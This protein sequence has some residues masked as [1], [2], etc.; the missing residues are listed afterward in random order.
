MTSELFIVDIW[1]LYCSPIGRTTIP[2]N[3][4]PRAPEVLNTNE[5]VFMDES[6]D[7]ATYVQRFALFGISG[8]EVFGPMYA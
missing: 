1:Y 7:P 2:T 5:R 8:R 4:K 3:W 6:M